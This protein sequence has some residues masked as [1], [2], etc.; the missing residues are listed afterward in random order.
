MLL[1]VIPLAACS[2][3]SAPAG[4]Q[5]A[6]ATSP[7]RPPVVPSRTPG[8]TPHS[9]GPTAAPTHGTEPAALTFGPGPVSP[10]T[11]QPQPPPGTCHY[12][13]TAS[14]QPLP[15]RR[16]TPGA[17]N[18]RVT[19]QTLSS[20]IC[21]SGY[22]RSIR[23]PR[24]IT[25]REKAANAASYGYT[26][27]FGDAEYDHLVP[28]ELGGDPNSALNLWVEPPSPGHRSGSGVGNP[29]D[30]VENRAKA[31]VCGGLVPLS[32]MQQAIAANWTTAIAAVGY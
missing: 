7:T 22:T 24:S 5:S 27:R 15:D 8:G 2:T 6:G 32:K 29:K 1:L 16:C 25:S 4:Q 20:T 28:L 31:L 21:R 3:V 23:P 30:G 12:R 26:G 14:G 10:Y 11:V 13:F 17:L 9:P 19:P 18:P